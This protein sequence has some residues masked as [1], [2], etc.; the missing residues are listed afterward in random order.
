MLPCAIPMI[1]A[2]KCVSNYSVIQNL[3]LNG[4]AAVSIPI[5]IVLKVHVTCL[6]VYLS[7]LNSSLIKYLSRFLLN[8]S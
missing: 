2:E 7:D 8:L 4:N 1:Y 3:L 6:T 5:R